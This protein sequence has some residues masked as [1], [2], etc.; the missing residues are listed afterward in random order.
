MARADTLI[1]GSK[2]VITNLYDVLQKENDRYLKEDPDAP[3]VL[4]WL[5]VPM[6]NRPTKP[7]PAGEP[8]V[9]DVRYLLIL[10]LAEWDTRVQFRHPTFSMCEALR[11][12]RFLVLNRSRI[13]SQLVRCK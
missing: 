3:R 1:W 12:N 10:A 5:H 2:T 8:T 11:N 9:Y 4:H 13:I 6:F 7:M